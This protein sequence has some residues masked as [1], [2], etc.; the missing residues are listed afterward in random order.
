M[1]GVEIKARSR[2]DALQARSFEKRL[3]ETIKGYEL[4]ALTTITG[5]SCPGT[6]G[7]WLPAHH[8]GAARNLPGTGRSQ[9]GP[10]LASDLGPGA[11]ENRAPSKA[12]RR[13][14]S[15][16]GRRRKSQPRRSARE[17]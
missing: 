9:S 12:Q 13:P 16:Y 1:N 3:E 11:A 17:D 14:S 10:A 6:S 8:C 7:L 5:A 15:Y 2:T 4:R